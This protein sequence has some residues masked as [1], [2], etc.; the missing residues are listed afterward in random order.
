MGDTAAVIGLGPI[1]Q[2]VT[3]YLRVVGARQVL[4]IDTVAGRLD[5]AAAH[6]ATAVF[7][8]TAEDAK[9]FIEKHTDGEGADVVYDASGNWRVLPHAIGLA[10]QF[11][12]V[13]LVGDTPFPTRQHLTHDVLSRQVDIRGT[14]NTKLQPQFAHWT[15][16]RQIKLFYTYL[17]RGQMRVDD[18]ITHQFRP[19]DA[20]EA[21]MKMDADRSDMLGTMFDW[22]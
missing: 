14:H 3:Q 13:M 11:G 16:Q 18:L 7:K 22:R 1:G 4:A 9:G 15:R 20:A 10:R 19:A 17:Q 6:G 2:L 12:V 5:A 8:G 21:F